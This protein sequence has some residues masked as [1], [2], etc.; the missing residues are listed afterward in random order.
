MSVVRILGTHG[1]PSWKGK[2]VLAFG[3]AAIGQSGGPTAVINASACGVIINPNASDRTSL[4]IIAQH[5]P[6]RPSA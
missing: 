4:R 5:L 1:V 6:H 2:R 3:N